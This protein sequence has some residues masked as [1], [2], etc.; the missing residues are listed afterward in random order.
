[1]K[2]FVLTPDI[3]GNNRMKD[4][5]R[6][7]FVCLFCPGVG[8]LEGLNG[9]ELKRLLEETAV[10]EGADGRQPGTELRQREMQLDGIRQFVQD[11]E[12]G[13]YILVR[14][15]EEVYWGDLGDYYYVQQG[16]QSDDGSCHRRGVTWLKSIPFSEVPDV[17]KLLLD[18]G[19]PIARY[20]EDVT[21][22]QLEFWFSP[23]LTDTGAGTDVEYSS[24]GMALDILRQAMQHGDAERRERAAAAILNYAASR[25]NQT[26]R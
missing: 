13:D 5:V 8:D 3:N 7:C 22:A 10:G 9:K 12:D 19:I 26:K 18:Q 4:F 11:M 23:A 1:M 14:N 25:N 2:L 24:I 20:G 17:L 15:G 21:H 16:D 6:D